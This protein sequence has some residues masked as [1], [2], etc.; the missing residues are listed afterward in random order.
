[1]FFVLSIIVLGLTSMLYRPFIVLF[2]VDLLLYITVA[3]YYAIAVGKKKDISII[4]ILWAYFAL[5]IAYGLGSLWGVLTFL[6]KFPN[7][8]RQKAGKSLADRM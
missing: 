4:H 2:A 8:R 6:I 5:H 1:M 3:T 7:P